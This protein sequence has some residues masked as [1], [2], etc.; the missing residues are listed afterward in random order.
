MK[1]TLLLVAS[2]LISCLLGCAPERGVAESS[3]H[4]DSA[5]SSDQPP[6]SKPS[7]EILKKRIEYRD[8]LRRV[9]E[10]LERRYM[11]GTDNFTSLAKANIELAEAELAA[12]STQDKRIVALETLVEHAKKREDYAR[13]RMETGTGRTDE[14]ELATAGRLRAELMLLE[15]KNRSDLTVSVESGK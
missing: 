2:I 15:E 4:S 1:Q 14:L 3:Q 9:V 12:A 10:I 5:H 11:D 7:P 13:V 6:D 8:T